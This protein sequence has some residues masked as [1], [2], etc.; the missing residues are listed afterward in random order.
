M[1]HGQFTLDV[2][3][4][5]QTNKQT[6]TNIHTHTHTHTL[7]ICNNYCFF[8]ASIVA[9][10][11]RNITL[12]SHCLSFPAKLARAQIIQIG[13]V[14]RRQEISLCGCEIYSIIIYLYS[15]LY[16]LAN[17]YLSLGMQ[18]WNLWLNVL[19]I[20]RRNYVIT[21]PQIMFCCLYVEEALALLHRTHDLDSTYFLMRQGLRTMRGSLPYATWVETLFLVNNPKASAEP[22]R[23]PEIS[24]VYQSY[25]L[26]TCLWVFTVSRR[27][28]RCHGMVPRYSGSCILQNKVVH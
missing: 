21:S 11:P 17:V 22:W 13:Y 20:W 27:S 18:L 8:T 12:Y 24:Q 7:S 10:M 26:T 6:N 19:S 1:A 23:K 16:P 5:K 14:L 2:E 25:V 15:F 4:Y 28:V 9:R 3:G